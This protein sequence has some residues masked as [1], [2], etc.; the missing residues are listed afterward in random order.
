MEGLLRGAGRDP[1]RR[2][3]TDPRRILFLDVHAA[4]YHMAATERRQRRSPVAAS[5]HH[6]SLN[7]KAQYR[8]EIDVQGVLDTGPSSTR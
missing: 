6:G 7:L 8:F 5:S 2:L 4:R 1:W 3:G